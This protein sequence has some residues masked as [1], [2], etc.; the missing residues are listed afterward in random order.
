M[1]D[2]RFVQAVS[3][4]R[5]KSKWFPTTAGV[6]EEYS[7]IVAGIQ[8]EFK[9]LPLPELTPE[10]AQKN[11]DWIREHLRMKGLGSRNG[12]DSQQPYDP[13]DQKEHEAKV[14]EQAAAITSGELHL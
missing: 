13:A 2:A 8:P 6:N 12:G 3:N 11:K 9:M 7:A 10:Q 5:K 1:L 14:R 4:C